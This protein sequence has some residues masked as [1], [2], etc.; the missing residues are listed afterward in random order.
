MEAQLLKADGSFVVK[1]PSADAMGRSN[2]ALV[3]NDLMELQLPPLGGP[4]TIVDEDDDV[5]GGAET[6][7]EAAT[8]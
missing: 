6:I 2:S 1:T 7:V 8:S 3:L 4:K 5:L